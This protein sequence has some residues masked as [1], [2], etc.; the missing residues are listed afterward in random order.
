MPPNNQKI[1]DANNVICK[2]FLRD[3]VYEAHLKNNTLLECPVC[4][5]KIDCKYCFCLLSCG[6]YAHSFCLH[7]VNKCPICRN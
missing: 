5:D 3:F 2:S 4:L 7:R 1:N 6:H